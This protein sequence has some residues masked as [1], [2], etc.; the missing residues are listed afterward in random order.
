[1]STQ[2]RKPL[3]AFI[4]LVFLAAG[5]VGVQ[6]ADA[7]AGRLLAAAVG[8]GVRVHGA[9]PAAPEPSATTAGPAFE[10]LSD[11]SELHG[12]GAWTVADAVPGPAR[13]I[14]REAADVAARWASRDAAAVDARAR[15]IPSRADVRTGSRGRA[16]ISAAEERG[17]HARRSASSKRPDVARVRQ[18][19]SRR[20]T[21]S[22]APARRSAR[23]WT[24]GTAPAVTGQPAR[25]VPRPSK[26]PARTRAWQLPPRGKAVHRGTRAHRHGH[27]HRLA[28]R[29]AHRGRHAHGPLRTA[30]RR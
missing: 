28:H 26:A 15:A 9:L 22:P 16:A 7:Q 21:A 1:M 23:A 30:P 18:D 27:A 29:L 6:K 24:R 8:T 11:P 17:T 2:H 12:P 5:V 19:L 13:V 14:G 4:V 3:A 10:A 25:V 20:P